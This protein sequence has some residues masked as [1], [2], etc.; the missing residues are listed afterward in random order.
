MVDFQVGPGWGANPNPGPNH[1]RLQRSHCMGNRYLSLETRFWS[2]VDKTTTPEGCW[3]WTG[4]VHGDGYGAITNKGRSCSAHRISWE[5]HFGPIPK[6]EGYFGT[7]VCHTCDVQLC[8]APHHL[9]LG[10]IYDNIR[11]KVSKGRNPHGEWHPH[12]KL[13]EAAVLD[14]RASDLPQATLAFNH[15]V[16]QSVIS[17]VRLRK[18]WRHVGEEENE[19]N[20]TNT[21]V[22]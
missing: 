8:V 6:G 4:P 18:T 7:C 13:T 16:A 3:L 17:A 20:V 15:G 19:S 21:A 9:F 14:I 1:K 2:R 5:L 22:S 11:D 10:S 12:V